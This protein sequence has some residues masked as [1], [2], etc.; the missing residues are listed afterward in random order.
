MKEG[1]LRITSATSAHLPGTKPLPLPPA[2]AIDRQRRAASSAG[3]GPLD[4]LAAGHRRVD[5]PRFDRHHVHT[6]A[7]HPVAQRLEERGERRLRG[8]VPRVAAPP[9]L[10]GDAGDPEDGPAPGRLEAR[11][12]DVHP[13]HRAEEVHLDHRAVL[14][15]GVL[16]LDHLGHH[17]GGVHQ[18]V[19]PAE[20]ALDAL[21]ERRRRV[22]VDH[23]VHVRLHLDLGVRVL[24]DPGDPFELVLP[25]GDQGDGRG[26]GAR[27]LPRDR[28]ADSGAGADHDGSAQRYRHRGPTMRCPLAQLG[29]RLG[30]RR[31]TGVAPGPGR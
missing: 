11:R 3:D 20:V 30:G 19:D 13:G 18:R 8:V 7:R 22:E 24:D 2:R 1:M 10:A 4:P 9:A 16:A 17:A 28:L 21:E 29:D 23:V 26:P 14:G 31:G 6:V 12:R 15:E 25:P 27:Q 5:E